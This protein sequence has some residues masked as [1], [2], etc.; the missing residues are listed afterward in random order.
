MW[1]FGKKNQPEEPAAEAE[2][3]TTDSAAPA[4]EEATATLHDDAS[5][6]A[7]ENA[8]ANGPFD[9]SSASPTQFDF[10]RLR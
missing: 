8:P 2:A 7:A 9:I 6:T 1:P 4:S 3:V 5:E 10:F